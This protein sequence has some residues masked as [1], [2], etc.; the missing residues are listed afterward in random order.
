M[1]GF[2]KK[3]KKFIPSRKKQSPSD[4][5]DATALKT[6]ETP[7]KDPIKDPKKDSPK[8]GSKDKEP[9]ENELKKEPK[10]KKKKKISI[11]LI[12]IIF[13]VLAAIGGAGFAAYTFFLAP[14]NSEAQA[15]VQKYKKIEL[16]N[17]QLPEELLKFS[18][19]Y[20]PDVYSALVTYNNEVILLDAEIKRIDAIGLQYPEQK[21]IADKE[22]KIWE[23]TRAGLEK[24]FLKIQKPVKEIY[25]LFRVNKEQGLAQIETRHAELAQ[26]ANTALAPVQELTRKLKTE[27]QVP[28]GLINSTLYKIKK[29]FL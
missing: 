8:K 28:E 9:Q 5:Q 13:L 18:F 6:D 15:P 29:K 10:V 26:L 7:K 21:K 16:K 20:L 14:K 11:K 1:L 23:K 17:L 22:K 3:L 4:E 12:L 2:L 19:D 25:V 24:T 27:E